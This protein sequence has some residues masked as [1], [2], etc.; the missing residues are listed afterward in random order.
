M[1]LPIDPSTTRRHN[2]PSSLPPLSGWIQPCDFGVVMQPI[3]WLEAYSLFLGW[4]L[5]APHHPSNLCV[6]ATPDV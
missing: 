4:R 3:S 6:H 1:S 5:W 2:P